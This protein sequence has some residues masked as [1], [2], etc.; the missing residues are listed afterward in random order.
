MTR[1]NAVRVQFGRRAEAYARS[2]DHAQGSD[3]VRLIE[4][5]A[6]RSEE[7]ALDV[8]TGTGFTALALAPHVVSVV[9]LDLTPE[10]LAEAQRLADQAGRENVEFVAGDVHALPFA[11]A[12]F[13]LVTVRRAPHHFADVPRALGEIHR[14]LKPE[15]RLGLSDQVPPDPPAAG[16]LI[17]EVERLR[18]PSHVQALTAGQWRALLASS[19]FRVEVVEIQTARRAL[20]EWLEVAGTPAKVAAT[21]QRKLAEAPAAVRRQLGYQG[22]GARATFVQR[23]LVAVARKVA[24]AR[25]F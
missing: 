11:D 13:D 1:Q 8:A 19:G 7:S 15:G 24:R 2:S 16:A 23:R 9:A 10:M 4:L 14:V 5:L 17:E 3:L 20:D 22:E 21:I 6:P 18:D 12:K 25:A